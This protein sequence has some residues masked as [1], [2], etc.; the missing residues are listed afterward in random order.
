ML[1]SAKI[2]EKRI[3]MSITALFLVKSAVLYYNIQGC[4]YAVSICSDR[5]Q[6]EA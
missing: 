1:F 5:V 4:Y 2:K 3:N 6:G